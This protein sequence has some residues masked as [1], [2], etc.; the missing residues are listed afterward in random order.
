MSSPFA[1]AIYTGKVR[2]RRFSPK[3]HEFEYD[4]FMMYLDTREIENVFSL[5]RLWS[6]MQDTD[7]RPFCA[8]KRYAEPRKD[9]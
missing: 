5:S 3:V 8:G 1:S 2:H 6:L 9:S 4:V 7:D